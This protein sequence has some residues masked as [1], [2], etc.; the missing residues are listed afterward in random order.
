MTNFKKI[1][2]LLYMGILVA[3]AVIVGFIS[4]PQLQAHA[5]TDPNE[6]LPIFQ[7][8]FTMIDSEHKV[9]VTLDYKTFVGVNGTV[10]FEMAPEHD[11]QKLETFGKYVKKAIDT[12]DVGEVFYV[13][14]NASD[15]DDYNLINGSYSFKI[16]LPKF[17]HNKEVAVIPFSDYRTTQR[18]KQ[19]EVDDEGYIKFTGNSNAY[20]YAIVYNG[21]YKQIILIGI[22]ML[23]LL[24]IC[25]LV[26]IYCL[27][28][29]N[30]YHKEKKAEKAIE[31]KKEKHK[32]NRR[33]AQE[34]KREKEK[35]K[36][37]G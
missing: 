8:K 33:L 32:I 24:I 28:K 31:K 11:E 36:K 12:A 22:I 27:R 18:V 2:S 10:E 17:Y 26:K 29:D 13:T 30:P 21:V 25:V 6:E 3:C 37:K 34:L 7:K 9:E 14:A 5:E 1:T 19:A 16:K 20:A 15:P 35:L 4:P 23:S